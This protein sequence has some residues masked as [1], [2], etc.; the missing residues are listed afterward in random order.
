MVLA[1][2]HP[3]VAHLPSS[4]GGM[5]V[6]PVPADARPSELT[7]APANLQRASER[8]GTGCRERASR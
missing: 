7:P 8:Y 4:G 1:L 5:R 2:G 3:S 6:A